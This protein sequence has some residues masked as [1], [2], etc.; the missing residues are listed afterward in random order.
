MYCA[1]C[2]TQTV[3]DARFCI[4][5]GEQ[6]IVDAT[7][8]ELPTP[9]SL[10]DETTPQGRIVSSQV[11]RGFRIASLVIL[12]L[13]VPICYAVL[14]FGAYATAG[15]NPSD[16]SDPNIK[17]GFA[18]LNFWVIFGVGC[19][20]ALH[21]KRRKLLWFFVGSVAGWIGGIIIWS[22]GVAAHSMLGG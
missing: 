10:P 9:T 18:T 5:C 15:S 4:S 6:L 16:F 19:L 1:S 2:G 20:C 22:I 3:K 11:K 14:A 13:I 17:R 21:L 7:P 12:W 8:E